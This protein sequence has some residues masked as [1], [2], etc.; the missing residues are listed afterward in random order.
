MRAVAMAVL[1]LAM[2]LPVAA[3][4]HAQAGGPAMMMEMPVMHDFI[5]GVLALRGPL[6]LTAE[7]VARLEALQEAAS[8]EAMHHEHM[9]DEAQ[10]QAMRVLHHGGDIDLTAHEAQVK[11]AM[12]HRSAAMM[13]QAR[14]F[15]EARAVLT[16]TQR[17]KLDFAMQVVAALMGMDHGPAAGGHQH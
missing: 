14:R 5:G 10:H 7:Q 8:G 11:A 13:S 12:E 4:Q 1:G 6:E 2:S 17:E 9:A 15:A 16:P 3:Q